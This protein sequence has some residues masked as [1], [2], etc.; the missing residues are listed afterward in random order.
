MKIID[1]IKN[2]FKKKKNDDDI[3]KEKKYDKNIK[4]NL[5]MIKNSDKISYEDKYNKND[6]YIHQYYDNSSI[7]SGISDMEYKFIE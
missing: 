6:I 3:K 7:N 2:K 5:L 1:K 4:D